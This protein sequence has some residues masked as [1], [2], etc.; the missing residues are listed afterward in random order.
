METDQIKFLTMWKPPRQEHFVLCW[1][2]WRLIITAAEIPLTI[3]EFDT[4]TSIWYGDRLDK[5]YKIYGNLI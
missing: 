3:Y 5:C 1:D 4:K 2:Y